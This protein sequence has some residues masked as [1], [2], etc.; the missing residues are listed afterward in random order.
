MIEM[1]AIAA[2]GA[3]A[4]AGD[5]GSPAGRWS[6]DVCSNAAK[7]FLASPATIGC[8]ASASEDI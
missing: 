6:R 3:R 2:G 1:A 5:A 4:A 8:E 7:F